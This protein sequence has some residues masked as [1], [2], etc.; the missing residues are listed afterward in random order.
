MALGLGV[1][2]VMLSS[3]PILFLADL[4]LFVVQVPQFSPPGVVQVLAL[5]WFKSTAICNC[6]SSTLLFTSWFK[7]I[8]TL[9]LVYVLGHSYTWLNSL[10]ILSLGSSPQLLQ[11]SGQVFDPQSS[12]QFKSLTPISSG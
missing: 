2:L 5:S 8:T 1:L 6:G 10:I 11:I 3:T 7:S 4:R 12:L 9:T